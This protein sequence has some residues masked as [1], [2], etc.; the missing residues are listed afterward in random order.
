MRMLLKLAK[1]AALLKLHV[2]ALQRGVNRFVRCDGYVDQCSDLPRQKFHYGTLGRI[3]ESVIS[4]QKSEIGPEPFY[5]SSFTRFLDSSI[6]RFFVSSFPRFLVLRF[7]IS[8]S[9]RLVVSSSPRL[10][11]SWAPSPNTQHPT[12]DT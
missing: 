10:L 9:R 1:Q 2:E 12:P 4:S 7:F 11:V 8:S 5:R 3:R 6:L